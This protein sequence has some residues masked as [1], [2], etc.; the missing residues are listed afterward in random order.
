MKKKVNE[1]T[2][3]IYNQIDELP[4]GSLMNTVKIL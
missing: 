2:G 4:K 1:G 3:N